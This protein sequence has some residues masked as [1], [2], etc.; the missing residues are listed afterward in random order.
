MPDRSDFWSR[1]RR[2]VA[3]EE[4]VEERAADAP[5]EPREAEALEE[6][7]DAELLE[8][9]GLPDPDTLTPADAARFMARE[10]PA[11][12][13]RRA[14]RSLFQNHPELSM[15]DGLQDYDHDYTDAGLASRPLRTLWKGAGRMA[16][17][18]REIAGAGQADEGGAEAAP[19]TQPGP[20][21][22]DPDLLPAAAPESE[23]PPAAEEDPPRPR[24]MVFRFEEPAS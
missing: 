4:A 24:R 10:I 15:P 17:A 23:P 3:A 18:G 5:A 9:F 7:S 8:M 6:R 21:P 12:L 16:A 13:R 2:A 1:R 14:F 11:R 22:A 20:P 19:A